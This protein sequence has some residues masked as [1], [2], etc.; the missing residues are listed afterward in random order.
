MVDAIQRLGNADA[1]AAFCRVFY[2]D[3][4]PHVEELRAIGC[5]TLVLLGEFDK[6]FI[7]PGELLAREIPNAKHVVMKDLGHM[8]AIEAPE[9]LLGELTSFLE[10]ISAR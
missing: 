2:T 7:T 1:L 6:V 5:P 8:T 4:D 10:S 3:P 9:A